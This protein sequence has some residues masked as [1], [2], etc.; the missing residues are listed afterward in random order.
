M[1]NIIISLIVGLIIAVVI[2]TWARKAI[3]KLGLENER[4][5]RKIKRLIKE[6]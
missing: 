6:K 2:Y 3:D 5:N 1:Y 4:L